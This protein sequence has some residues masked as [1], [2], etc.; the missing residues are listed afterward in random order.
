MPGYDPVSTAE[1]GQWFDVERA[2]FSVSFFHECLQFIEGD[3]AGQ[4]FV[5]EPW[6]QAILGCMFGWKNADGT[7]RYR[8]VF[9]YVP[10]KN[11]KTPFLA[12]IT[13]LVMFTD[14]EPGAQIYSAAAEREQAAIVFRHASG[15]ILREPELEQRAEIRKS[16]RTIDYPATSGLYKALSADA[17]T[18]HGGNSHFIVVDE[19]H[20]HPNGELVDV[21]Q[22]STASRKQPMIVYITTADYDRESVCNTKY[23][24]ATKVRD[25][26][27]RDSSFLP[28]LYEASVDDDW[29]SPE[30]WHKANPNL[31]V[32]VREDYFERETQRAINEPTYENTFKRL[33]L[34][35][36]TQQDVRWIRLEQW[37]KCGSEFD[38]SE[39]EGQ[40]C[41]AGLD[42]SQ[43][44]DL[45]ALALL[46]ERG[47]EICALMRFWC[48]EENI[49]DR[50]KR[51]RVD[52]ETW[53][54][55]GLITP[56]PGNVVD[57][58]IIRRDIGDLATRFEIKE[59]AADPW[60]A[61]QLQT[62][63]M[64][65]GFEVIE[66]RQGYGSLSSASKEFEGLVAAGRFNHGK[67]P[68]LRWMASHVA[69]EMDAAGNIKPSKKKSTERIDGIAAI[70][71]ALARMGVAEDNTYSPEVVAY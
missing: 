27:I 33:H 10:R 57:Y 63:L 67:H 54:R 32:S 48:P 52:Y 8:E 41:F 47:D 65:D 30:T 9:L 51:D 31:G 28:V 61:Q 60:Q 62:Q 44:F 1:D 37:D 43:K 50:S 29:T 24:Y 40:V 4:P 59:I 21:L 38:E 6:Q 16:T 39:F 13:L 26:V 42:L 55:K 58:D 23:D 35:I 34:N 25:Q 2:E 3:K 22:T 18:K 71:N 64:G 20:A 46:F 69:A 17:D 45:S 56:T 15:M 68:M 11:G 5:L 70:V 12:G 36:R 19:L 14:N 53:A 66:M 7:R 49:R